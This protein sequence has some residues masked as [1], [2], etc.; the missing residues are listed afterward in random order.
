MS[1]AVALA[2]AAAAVSEGAGDATDG[3][4]RAGDETADGGAADSAGADGAG[5]DSGADA[6]GVNAD[7]AGE[8][9]AALVP[10]PPDLVHAVSNDAPTSGDKAQL[11]ACDHPHARQASGLLHYLRQ[12][13]ARR[14]TRA[15]CC[16]V[17]TDLAVP[18]RL[19]PR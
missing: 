18:L 4:V 10:V 14:P 1:L 13:S 12:L 8:A 15:E 6:D 9:L 16:R 11:S 3:D 5:D 19:R 7:A 2:E 17:P